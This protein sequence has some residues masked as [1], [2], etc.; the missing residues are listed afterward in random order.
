M[1]ARIDALDQAGLDRLDRV[2]QADVGRDVDHAQLRR[3]QHHRDLRRRRSAG[4][5]ARC[6]RGSCGRRGAAPPCSA[7]RC[8]WRRPR[9]RSRARPRASGLVRALARDC[10]ESS[11]NGRSGSIR[12][13][14]IQ[15]SAPSGTGSPGR[16]TATTSTS[17]SRMDGGAAQAFGVADDHHAR[18]RV[19]ADDDLGPDP[20]GVAHGH[21]DPAHAPPRMAS[22]ARHSVAGPPNAP[23]LVTMP[24]SPARPS[25]TPGSISATSSI[26][27]TPTRSHTAR[28]VSRR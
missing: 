20:G 13:R 25:G 26:T 4:R 23:A 28:A 17:A 19:R 1:A 12:S 16:S 3:G 7:A 8:R 22:T 21:R 14:S 10:A 11:P 27:V 6:G 2:D 18:L 9:P 24:R 5:A 15:A